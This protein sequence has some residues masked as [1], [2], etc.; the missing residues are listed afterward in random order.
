ML[1]DAAPKSPEAA[2]ADD[3]LANITV[4]SAKLYG[5][6]SSPKASSSVHC[7]T[8]PILT[9]DCL[10]PHYPERHALQ[11]EQLSGKKC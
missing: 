10:M 1:D 11:F 6:R 8:L 5:A 2:F 9:R 4:F 3:V 7:S